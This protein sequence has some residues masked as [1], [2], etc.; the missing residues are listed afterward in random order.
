MNHLSGILT[1]PESLQNGDQAM[2]DYIEI[3]KTEAEK[4]RLAG[5][6][7]ELLAIQKKML[8]KKAYGG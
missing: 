7:D 2:R 5:A 1:K 6:S 3:I 8:E 4:R